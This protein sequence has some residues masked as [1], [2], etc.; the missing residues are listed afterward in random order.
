MCDGQIE[1]NPVGMI[2]VSYMHENCSMQYKALSQS[3]YSYQLMIRIA[4]AVLDGPRDHVD[5]S[6]IIPMQHKCIR[7]IRLYDIIALCFGCYI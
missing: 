5:P 2:G 3:A 6:A 4:S 7:I 1:A